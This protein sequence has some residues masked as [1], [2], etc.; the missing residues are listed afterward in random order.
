MAKVLGRLTVNGHPMS[1]LTMNGF[2][3]FM[4][5][6]VS[7]LIVQCEIHYRAAFK[8]LCRYTGKNAIEECW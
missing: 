4:E 7:C 1:C 6:N 3:P 5:W 2:Q 8:L